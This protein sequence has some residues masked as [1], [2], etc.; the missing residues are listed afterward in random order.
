M[1]NSIDK[2]ATKIVD[3]DYKNSKNKNPFTQAAGNLR[4]QLKYSYNSTTS[5][6]YRGSMQRPNY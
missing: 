6:V 2:Y 5:R 1:K 3:N 4:D